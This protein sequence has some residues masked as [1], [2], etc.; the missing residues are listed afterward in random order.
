MSCEFNLIKHLT[1]NRSSETVVWLCNI[2]AEKYWSKLSAG[3]VDRNEDIAV[4]RIEELNLL[5]CKEQD[6][7]ILRKQPDG[8]YLQT[9]Q[10]LGFSVPIILCPKEPDPLTPISELV[11]KDEELLNELSAIASEKEDV[12]FF[13]YAVTCLEEE[14]AHKTGL[15]LMGSPAEINAKVNDKIFNREI[16]EAL[17]FEVCNG[18]VCSS[19]DEVR[20]EYNKLTEQA[21]YFNKVIIKEPRG[22]SGKGLYIIESK[23]KL[24]ASLRVIARFSKGKPE[25]KWLVE[26]WY[27]KKA[28]VNYQIYISPMGE[29]EVFSIKQQLLKETIYIGSKMPADLDDGVLNSFK[30][31]GEKIGKYLFDIGYVGVAGV[32]SIITTQNVII[33]IIEI[34]GRCT[35]STY[36]SFVN[37]ILG[38]KKMLTRY[39]R[40]MPSEPINYTDLCERLDLNNI[41]IKPDKK[42][43]VFVY[44]AGSLPEFV[45]EGVGTCFGRVFSLIIADDWVKVEYYNNLLE[46]VMDQL[47]R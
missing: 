3:V 38:D 43:G 20:E 9:L 12:F 29:V 42:E 7:L 41:L 28:D 1:E 18:R 40:L 37:R 39:F 10:A 22:A 13:P 34:N 11:L 24:E 33:P 45:L 46:S 4:N 25:C 17:D 44:T 15:R 26:G 19:I 21:P 23:E 47:S 27:D 5:I 2:G 6:V 30:V 32:D 14:I 36:I 16:A 35:L 31:Y 8:K